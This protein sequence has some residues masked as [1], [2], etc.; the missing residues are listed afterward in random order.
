MRNLSLDIMKVLLS[1]F[2][3]ANHAEF[4]KDFS[5]E[6][7]YY[8]TNSVLRI[9]VPFF[10]ISSGYFFYKSID[11]WGS[12]AFKKWF[13]SILILHSFWSLVYLYYY[14]PANST[15][16]EIIIEI[17][18]RYIE[19]YWHL[20]FTAGLLGS[21]AIMYAIKGLSAMQ[22]I[23]LAISLFILGCFFQYSGNYHIFDGYLD[24]VLNK[25]HI[26]RNFLFFSLPFLISGFLIAK[27]KTK[28]ICKSKYL[29][30][31]FFISWILLAFEGLMNTIFIKDFNQ[32]F[33]ILIFQPFLAITL[34]L[35]LIKSNRK[36]SSDVYSKLSAGVYFI[37]PIF[38]MYFSKI[39]EG[40][41]MVFAISVIFSFMASCILIGVSRRIKF[42][43]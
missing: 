2:V 23:F 8:L 22:L 32:G 34:F 33:D 24:K 11:K 14:I 7:N 25:T 9:S 27:F 16:I 1:V 38:L 37:H 10:Y 30:L 4:L 28:N 31:G 40:K 39:I 35:F 6:L 41:F 3:I 21:I 15:A 19:G 42:I 29:F 43:L 20:W 17:S 5:V 13:I 18:K 26:Y 12:Y 36:I